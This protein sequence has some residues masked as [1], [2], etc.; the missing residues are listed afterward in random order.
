MESKPFYY[1]SLS[2]EIRV[3]RRWDHQIGSIRGLEASKLAMKTLLVAFA[4]A[5]LHTFPEPSQ[6]QI[7]L[8]LACAG[9]QESARVIVE[10][11]GEGAT[12]VL[13]G[14]VVGNYRWYLPAEMIFEALQGRL[15]YAPADLPAIAGRL[16]PWVVVL[17]S[18]SSFSFVVHAI[19]FMYGFNRLSAFAGDLRVS[20]TGR[21]LT[22]TRDSGY[23]S[24]M[25]VGQLWTG[26]A[27][28][29]SLH[30]ADCEK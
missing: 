28:S 12:G 20:L 22:D 2:C 5:Q 19:D 10:N 17:P 15:H 26:T 13:L 7:S 6:G 11:T 9:G 1:F 3:K 23:V 25:P 30:I 27:T 16:D 4:V 24:G 18:K 8:A 14:A 21:A 29:N